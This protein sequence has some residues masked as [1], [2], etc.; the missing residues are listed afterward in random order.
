MKI[1][2]IVQKTCSTQKNNHLNNNQLSVG[3]DASLKYAAQ[4]TQPLEQ[5]RAQ[6]L[7]VLAAEP[8]T[9]TPRE[10]LADDELLHIL[11]LHALS[12]LEPLQSSGVKSDPVQAAD[13]WK[14]G[15]VV[16]EE[17]TTNKLH[18]G[19]L[20]ACQLEE[21]L[22]VWKVQL[23]RVS[24][25]LRMF[26]RYNST[27]EQDSEQQACIRNQMTSCEIK[28]VERFALRL[29]QHQTALINKIE[30]IQPELGRTQCA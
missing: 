30:V 3:T 29:R 14:V 19:E 6:P 27:I 8:E 12:I 18:D 25:H 10:E 4:Q 23:E 22:V 20:T 24:R 1:I 28:E 21:R 15:S 16:M 17:Q 13:G 5:P 7:R 9:A 11:P 26:S 2:A